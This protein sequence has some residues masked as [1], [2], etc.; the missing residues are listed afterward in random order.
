MVLQ[1]H[2]EEQGQTLSDQSGAFSGDLIGLT[3]KSERP[4]KRFDVIDDE[5]GQFRQRPLSSDPIS[6]STIIKI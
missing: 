1:L 5:H 6:C 2:G 3:E 4:I